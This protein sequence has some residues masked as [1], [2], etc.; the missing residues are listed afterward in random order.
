MK[1]IMRS[2]DDRFCIYV[3]LNQWALPLYINIFAG[4]IDVQILCLHLWFDWEGN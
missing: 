1:A 2:E 4:A 3:T